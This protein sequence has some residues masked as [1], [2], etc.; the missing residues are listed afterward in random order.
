MPGFGRD[1]AQPGP[2][3]YSGSRSC[4]SEASEPT[5]RV[6]AFRNAA[7]AAAGIPAEELAERAEAGTLR[8]LSGIGEVTAR[9]ITESLRGEEP[10]YLRRLEATGGTPVAEGGAA[11]RAA[12]RGD[13]HTHSDWSDGGSRSWRWP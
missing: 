8:E 9:C 10:V 5:F 6:R 2:R 12:L 3:T 4:W 13:C 7:A 11:L 1:R